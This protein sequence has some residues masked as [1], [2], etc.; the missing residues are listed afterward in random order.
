MCICHLF[1]HH[2]GH[3]LGIMVLVEEVD[4]KMQMNG[5]VRQKDNGNKEQLKTKKEVDR[6]DESRVKLPRSQGR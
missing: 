5:L 3:I 4:G 1:S 2:T 6:K